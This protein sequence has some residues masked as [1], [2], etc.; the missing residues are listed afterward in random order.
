VTEVVCGVEPVPLPEPEPVVA[1]VT[2]VRL[3]L[4]AV[5]S[6]DGGTT[7]LVPAYL[8]EAHFPGADQPSTEVTLAVADE[9]LLPPADAPAATDGTATDDTATDD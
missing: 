9:F 2:G 1:E 7:L 5:P 8:W 6:A 3:G 4:A